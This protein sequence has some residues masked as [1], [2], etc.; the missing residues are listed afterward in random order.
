MLREYFKNAHI[1]GFE[2][3][4]KLIEM[5]K[6]FYLPN[7]NYYKIDVRNPNNIKTAFK[8]SNK[9]YDI[10][11]DD[12][13]HEFKDQI[14]VIYNTRQFMK[15]NSYLIIEDIFTK[16]NAYNEKNY[17]EELKK[18]KSEFSDITFIK[19]NHKYN[20]AGFWHNHKVLCLRK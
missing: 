13:T 1:N 15:K 11:I 17:Y 20:Y 5:A 19:C 3:D 4:Q 12:S 6:N 8:H 18:I 10:I 16:K 9:K 2:Y 7:T 14:N